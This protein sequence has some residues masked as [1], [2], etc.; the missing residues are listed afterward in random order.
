MSDICVCSSPGETHSRELHRMADLI[1]AHG[2]LSSRPWP[3][4]SQPTAPNWNPGCRCGAAL[5]FFEH[6]QHVAEV[7]FAAGFAPTAPDPEPEHDRRRRLT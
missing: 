3:D 6:D 2:F 7:L 1:R 4:G 5:Y